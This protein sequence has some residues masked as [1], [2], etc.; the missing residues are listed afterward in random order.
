MP[1]G[2]RDYYIDLL[3]YDRRLRCLVALELKLGEFTP[4]HLG[5]MQF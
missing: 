4:E 3:I 5:K 1:V 2:D